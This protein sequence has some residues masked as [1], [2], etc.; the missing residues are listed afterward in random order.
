MSNRVSVPTRRL[1]E[2]EVSYLGLGLMGMSYAYGAVDAEGTTEALATINAAIDAG[3]TLLDTADIYGSGHNEQLLSQVLATRRDEVLVATKFGILLD[4]ATGMPNGKVDGRPEYV[5]EAVEN[6]L[7]R[8]G[9]DT[10]DLYYQ[11]R[12]D[13]SVPIEDTIGAMADL[14]TAGK[15]RYLGLSEPSAQTL[16]RAAAVHPIAAVQSEWSIFSRDIEHDV[17]PAAREVGAGLVPYSPLGRGF[18]TGDARAVNPGSGDFR[19]T[20]PRW[21][22]DARAANLKLVDT[23]KEIAAR[24]DVTSAQVALAWLLAQGDDVVPIPGTRRRKFLA[25]NLGAATVRLTVDDLATLAALSPLGERYPDMTWVN[26][27]SA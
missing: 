4:P 9:I 12:V 25:E 20:L 18:L 10:I 22:G 19:A 11:H 5:R 26:R 27:D 8:L 1:G 14:V 15:V 17:V 7:R 6:S 13:P 21:Q 3:V 23:I 24:H 2:L 16:R